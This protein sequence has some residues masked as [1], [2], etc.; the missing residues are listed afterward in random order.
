MLILSMTSIGACIVIMSQLYSLGV[1]GR[2]CIC[3]QINYIS[4]YCC[5]N[6]EPHTSLRLIGAP[7]AFQNLWGI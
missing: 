7:F 6:R 2:Y 4:I 3:R 5:R 1:N